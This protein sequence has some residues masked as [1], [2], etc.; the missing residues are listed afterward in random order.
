MLSCHEWSEL[1]VAQMMH[2]IYKLIIIY[3]S[4]QASYVIFAY[5]VRHL[6]LDNIQEFY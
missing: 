5:K 1:I 4:D 3:L 6:Q 2:I